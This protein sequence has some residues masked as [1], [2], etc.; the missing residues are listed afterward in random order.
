MT[1]RDQCVLVKQ[2]SSI[3]AQ[4]LG[5]AFPCLLGHCTQTTNPLLSPASFS[6][7]RSF[8]VACPCP[9][10]HLLLW[11]WPEVPPSQE[12]SASV[13]WDDTIM[14]WALLPSMQA[15]PLH[16]AGHQKVLCFTS[17]MDPYCCRSEGNGA[18]RDWLLEQWERDLAQTLLHAQSRAQI[19]KLHLQNLLGFAL[20]CV[21]VTCALLFQV[22]SEGPTAHWQEA[23]KTH[24]A[25]SGEAE[26]SMRLSFLLVSG[27][28]E[29]T[30]LKGHT[31]SLG[32][33]RKPLALVSEMLSTPGSHGFGCLLL[34]SRFVLEHC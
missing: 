22:A 11:V 1:F 26:D 17:V 4:P 3:M 24:C 32:K 10:D 33:Y 2:M 6:M 19:W 34:S 5:P 21:Y 20:P 15:Y 28:E 9:W 14:R 23:A 7:W 29:V 31:T 18:V 30:K 25:T 13:T 16:G 12:L 8:S 27:D